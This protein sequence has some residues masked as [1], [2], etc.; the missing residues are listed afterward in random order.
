MD[1]NG[2]LAWTGIRNRIEL[3]IKDNVLEA[4]W[5]LQ[6]DRAAVPYNTVV[7]SERIATRVAE[8]LRQCL[9]WDLQPPIE[10]QMR[11]ATVIARELNM[12]LSG[13]ALRHNLGRLPVIRG[14]LTQKPR[15]NQ[16]SM[17]RVLLLHIYNACQRRA[18][19]LFADRSGGVGQGIQPNLV[20]C[21]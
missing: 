19:P 16:W 4:W 14:S 5:R 13:N 15:K 3:P 2:W 12:T 9:N 17:L 8:G 20:R 21:S 11:Y 6:F 7:L 1:R 18:D 10:K